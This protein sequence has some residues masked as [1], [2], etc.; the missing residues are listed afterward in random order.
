MHGT[1]STARK[2]DWLSQKGSVR[3]ENLMC[4]RGE[5]DDKTQMKINGL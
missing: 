2:N 1:L 4:S 3:D 5:A